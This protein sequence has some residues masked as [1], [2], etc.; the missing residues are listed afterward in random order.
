MNIIIP[1]NNFNL[2]LSDNTFF[3]SDNI[4]DGNYDDDIDHRIHTFLN[5][6]RDGQIQS[7]TIPV[8]LSSNFMEFSGFIFAN[9]VRLTRELTFCDA[10][11]IFYGTLELEQLLR[12]T[13]LARILLTNNVLYVNIIKY[14]FED[15]QKS[16]ER[17]EIKQ[18]DINQF[19][20]QIQI[21]PPSNY[22][23]H[24]S[25]DNEFALIQWSRY[26]GCSKS[27]PSQFSK[28]YNSQL[29]FKYLRAKNPLSEINDD[30]QFSISTTAKTKILLVDDEA[31]KGWKDFYESFFKNS[32]ITSKDSEIEFKDSEVEFKN[33]EK[34]DLIAKVESKVREFNPDVVLLDLRIHDSDFAKEID[35]DNLTGIKILEKIK[36]INKGIQVIITTAS[37]KAWNFKLAKQKGAYDFIIKD[38]FENP[39]YSLKRLITSLEISVK[40][41]ITLKK[42]RDK[43]D[44]I[45]KLI[46]ENPH[47]DDTEN[48]EVIGQRENMD[49]VRNKF[50]SNLDSAF[51]LLDMSC[52]VS[53]KSK[54]YSYCYLQLFLCIEDFI[55]LESVFEIGDQSFVI[56]SKKRICV[57]KSN[58]DILEQAIKFKNGKYIIEKYSIKN[59]R[60]DSNFLVSSILIFKYGNEN[61]SI[62]KWTNVYTI[63]NN[64]AHEGFL[65]TETQ[66]ND[67]LKFMIYFFD[68]KSENEN[69]ISKGLTPITY[70]E[71]LQALQRKFNL[72]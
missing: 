50:I 18:F 34:D 61:S 69:N 46:D 71:G 23:S 54:Y 42:T 49:K 29:Y 58:N 41:A 19:F 47:F 15:I 6:K 17:Y 5:K 36:E 11:I 25:I 4:S 33:E 43:I 39:E 8:S 51:E 72:K 66:I 60:L 16:I 52:E 9:H 44:K 57:S 53:N 67:L 37:N 21:N 40:R 45:I 27:L 1:I 28:E 10:P 30:N 70:E 35:P 12:L 32:D 62:N 20:E 13:P 38:G 56:H 3:E 2:G 55:N 59:K 48:G 68:E 63:R 65:P 26:I 24:H 64:V 7:F 14:S 31:K 22:D